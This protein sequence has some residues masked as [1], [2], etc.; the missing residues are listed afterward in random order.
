MKSSLYLETSIVSYLAARPNRDLVHAAHQEMRT[1]ERFGDPL[2]LAM[3]T[4][5]VNPDFAVVAKGLG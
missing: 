1:K 5:P 3:K 2:V 4:E